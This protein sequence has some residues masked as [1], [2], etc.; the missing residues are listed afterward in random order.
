MVS[1]PFKKRNFSKSDLDGYKISRYLKVESYPFSC[2]LSRVG[3]QLTV[4]ARQDGF[5]S[6]DAFF[7]SLLQAQQE[8]EEIA[9]A[10]S[11]SST[12]P[13]M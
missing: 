9:A 8:L 3:N 6:S 13:E 1:I 10:S 4:R 5:A 11:S 2:L 7:A 12:Q